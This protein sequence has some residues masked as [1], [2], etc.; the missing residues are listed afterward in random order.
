MR[1]CEALGGLLKC[2]ERLRKQFP[3]LWESSE[4]RASMCMSGKDLTKPFSPPM[5]CCEVR[6]AV[7]KYQQ[8]LRNTF[9]HCKGPVK[10]VQACVCAEMT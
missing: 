3:P 10:L 4:A 8:R 5:R 9:H 7:F 2:Q 6:V 1:C